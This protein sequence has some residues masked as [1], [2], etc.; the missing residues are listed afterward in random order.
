MKLRPHL[1]SLVTLILLPLLWLW[2]FALGQRQ[3]V[4]YDVAQFPPANLTL[5][6][7][8]LAAARAGA[9]LDVTEVPVWFLPELTFAR[10]ELRAG[11]WPTWNPSARGG[12]PLHSHGLLGLC[13]PPNWLAL[14]ADDPASRL[15]LLAWVNLAI[16]GLA[17]YGLFTNAVT[18][19]L[20]AWF[21]A[22]S[23]QLA[24]PLAA[25]A[26]FW[27]RL[28]SFVWLPAVLWSLLHISKHE[29]LTPRAACAAAL[30]FAMPWL[31]GFPPFAATTTLLAGL[32]I[33][34]LGLQRG[35]RDGPRAGLPVLLR[36]AAPLAVGALLTLPQVLPSLLFF[37]ESARTTAPSLEHIG[38][39]R[40]DAYGLLGYLLPDLIGH[41]TTP[42]V[43]PYGQSPLALL[44]CDR[45]DAT[46]KG[47][48]PN[49]NYTEYAVF[50][51]TLGLALAWYGALV[52]RDRR[53]GFPALAWLLLLGLALFLPVVRWLF[54]LPLFA[55]VWPLRWLAPG[56]LLLAWLAAIGLDRLLVGGR[57]HLLRMGL[58][59]LLLG[60]LAGWWAGSHGQL[61]LEQPD[62]IVQAIADRVDVTPQVVREH[63]Q[64]GAELDRFA[65]A[66]ERANACASEARLW[67]LLFAGL[68]VLGAMLRHTP[69]WRWVLATTLAL[70]LL[71]LVQQGRALLIG[72]ATQA[73]APT[74]VH[75]FL[76]ERAMQP[77]TG[78]GFTFAR[79]SHDAILPAQLPPGQLL[80]DGLRDLQFY[81]HFDARSLAPLARIL[82]PD[83]RDNHTLRG[84]FTATLPSRVPGLLTHPYLDLCG[85]R[86]LLSTE[87]IPELGP[88]V[89]PTLQGP[90]GAFYV[91]ERQHALPRAFTVSRLVPLA[92]DEAV[93]EALAAPALQPRA[94]AYAC[95]SDCADLAALP[96]VE[97]EP[98]S[99]QFAE[100]HATSLQLDVGPGSDRWLVLADTYL[101][102]WTA[103]LD[104]E[105]VPILRVNH[106]MRGIHLPDAAA[107]R[108]AF[109]YHPPGLTLG[110]LLAGG[111]VLLLLAFAL[112]A[113]RIKWPATNQTLTP[114]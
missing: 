6:A 86:F 25:N 53:R 19:R 109:S 78:G 37:P 90:Q 13:Y 32:Y 42:N 10:D 114:R 83:V 12:A 80:G 4:P 59:V 3:F 21:A 103:Q 56:T 58:F 72:A 91:Y 38:L 92:D 74:A 23:F 108:V 94:Q 28:G 44:W 81:T 43:L 63:V 34:W 70:A 112:L 105:D 89:G 35:L 96:D 48:L 107:H 14:F 9:N 29:R 40:F 101:P 106:W 17:T 47:A 7:A 64:A 24:A 68:L 18:S 88:A 61:L 102:G 46:G 104:G 27:M 95:A 45:L 31:A 41:P 8:Q 49:Y 113:H 51:G 33:G 65:A 26:F 15:W 98:R 85:L 73:T 111:G 16:A 100:R 36:C 93:L 84:Y 39:S 52:G 1:A 60:L 30:C 110:W 20:A 77:P 54:H 66:G 75:A 22:A 82:P 5:S 87:A 97:A 79:V 2:P 69:A 67:G 76:R 99:V 50:F 71:Q 57:T 62:R 55:N 11:R